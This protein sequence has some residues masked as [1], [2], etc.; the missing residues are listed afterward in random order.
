MQTSKMK[1][2]IYCSY[3][4]VA[5]GVI[6][7]TMTAGHIPYMS[8]W[9]E[10]VCHHPLFSLQPYVLVNHMKAE[11]KR[12]A[13]M[14]ADEVATEVE[15][16]NLQVGFVA[17]LHNLGSIRHDRGV[18]G[19]PTLPIVQANLES[20]MELNYWVNY[21]QSKKFKFPELHISNLNDNANLD[22][23]RD[24]LNV[25][26]EQKKAY[27]LNINDL[28]EQE[29][30]RVAEKALL[31]LR[32]EWIKPAGKKLLWEFCK[33][34]L[35][36]Q[37]KS[38]A[39]GW[40]K[41]VFLST[42]SNITI[43]DYDEIELM[44]EIIFSNI[45]VGSSASHAVKERID[46]IKLDHNNHYNSFEIEETTIEFIETLKDSL[47]ATPAPVE[48]DFKNKAM[49]YVAKAKWELANPSNYGKKIDAAITDARKKLGEL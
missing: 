8:H 26:W 38:D 35:Q 25:C 9:N 13:Q 24:Y 16:Q 3:T 36:K 42:P 21:L 44:E 11:W 20:L 28:Q 17:M 14:I 43:W 22:N 46:Q 29:R 31:A 37:W 7:L 45:P 18:I 30:S 33:G 5:L 49:F 10:M 47:A 15:T 40:M 32:N 19:L 2:P 6:D 12:L 41:Q 1:H 23:I 34:Y 39:E 4:G 27:E 48:A